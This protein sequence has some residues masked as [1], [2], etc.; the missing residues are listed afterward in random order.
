[1]VPGYVDPAEVG[2]IAR[3]IAE[4]NPDIPYSLLAFYPQFFL[5]DLPT[6]SRGHAES[7]LAEARA[8]G[9]TRV[10]IGNEHLLGPD[11]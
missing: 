3:F 1:L 8:A 4:I 6:T 7:A 9:L 2:R 10:R 11:Y 5:S